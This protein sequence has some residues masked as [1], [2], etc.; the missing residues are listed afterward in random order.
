MY[1][2][3]K[4]I[5]SQKPSSSSKNKNSQEILNGNSNSKTNTDN[6]QEESLNSNVL[7]TG[8]K[9]NQTDQKRPIYK[10]LYLIQ[11]QKLREENPELT[12]QQWNTTFRKT[13][14]IQ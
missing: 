3:R 14:K 6:L 1:E 13:Y 5:E 10:N 9:Q 4:I 7:I 2:T 12:F 8:Q 11:V